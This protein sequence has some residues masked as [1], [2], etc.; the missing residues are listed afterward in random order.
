MTS[1]QLAAPPAAPDRKTRDDEI[2]IY[3]LTGAG[4]VR[5]DHQDQCIVS[6]SR[7]QIVFQLSNTTRM[8]ISCGGASGPHC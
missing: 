8:T 6:E 7:K 2:A 3:V 1:R 5:K 4:E